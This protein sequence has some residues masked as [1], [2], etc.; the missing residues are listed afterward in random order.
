MERQSVA[1]IGGVVLFAD[2][3][4]SMVQW[5][6]KHLGIFFTREPESH[7]WWCD[8]EG[9]KFSIHQTKHPLGRE[10]RLVE[11]TWRVRDLDDF[12]EHL[13]DLGTVVDERQEAP[14]GG[15]AWFDDPEGNRIELW[16]EKEQ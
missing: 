9:A 15:Y 8:C 5:Y 10:R 3:A 2:H 14:D 16:Q 13:A 4:D 6:E 11:I 1:G 12:V 7:D